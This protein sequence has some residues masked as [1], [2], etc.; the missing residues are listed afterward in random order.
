MKIKD[1]ERVDEARHDGPRHEPHEV[2]EAGKPGE[3][4]QDAGHDG[5]DQQVLEP[6]LLDQR[7]H[8]H[9][10]GGGGGRDHSGAATREGDDHGDGEGGIEPDL[11]VHARDDGEGDGLGN[12]GEG[13][14]E[15][16][17]DIATDVGKPVTAQVFDEGHWCPDSTGKPGPYD[18][19][20]AEGLGCWIVRR[21]GGRKSHPE[22]HRVLI[23]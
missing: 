17:Q 22:L 14:D 2:A 9:C 10:R 20:A 1:R 11:G 18:D 7:H 15:P 3:D 5:G 12:E 16:R 13:D 8:Q 4:L 6:V 23:R 19:E 21:I